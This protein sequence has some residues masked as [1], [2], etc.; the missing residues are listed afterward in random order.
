MLAISFILVVMNATDDNIVMEQRNLQN[1]MAHLI[2]I[3]LIG[4]NTCLCIQYCA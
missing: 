4:K 1:T 3:G 2:S